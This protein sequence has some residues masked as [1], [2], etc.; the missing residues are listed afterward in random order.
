MPNRRKFLINSSIAATGTLVLPIGCGTRESGSESSEETNTEAIAAIV[1]KDIGVQVYSVRDALKEDFGG[2][3][4]KLAEIGYKYIEAYGMDLEGQLFG[5]APA[6]YR[7]QVE[8]LGMQL[9]STHSTYFTPDHAEIMR[10]A[11]LEA[12]VKYLIIPYLS[13][14]LRSDYG[15]V[16]ENLNLVGQFFEGSGVKLGYHNH[17]FEFE[18]QN[19]Q[20]PFEILLNETEP[21]LVTF[22]ADLYW[23]T[24]GGMDPM[25]LINK[26]PGRFSLF[27]VKDANEE[28][29]QTTVGTGIVDFETIFNARETAGM[30]Y[31]FVEDERT[32]DPF[33]NMKANFDY[34]NTSDFV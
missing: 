32:D 19:D 4:K 26:F 33:G 13:D 5:M 25:D 8:D 29:E 9:I 11:A 18:T 14:D 20:I 12:G 21:N 1:N 34:M 23:V 10:D 17:A 16:A 7:N 6:N 15:Q 22:Q 28:L 30:E 31:F 27:H 3:L 2:S 24:V